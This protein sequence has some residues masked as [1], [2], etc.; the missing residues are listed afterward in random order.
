VRFPLNFKILSLAFVLLLQ[1][2]RKSVRLCSAGIPDSTVA[3]RIRTVN[4][5]GS[6]ELVLRM[7]IVCCDVINAS[8][9]CE[10]AVLYVYGSNERSDGFFGDRRLGC[11]DAFITTFGQP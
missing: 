3:G 4:T 2:V 11:G 9:C 8:E 10:L 6:V 7:R 1:A 5:A